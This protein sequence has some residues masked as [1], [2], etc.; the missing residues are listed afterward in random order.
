M[1]EKLVYLINEKEVSRKDFYY[2]LRNASTKLS[3]C[4]IHEIEAE[5]KEYRRKKRD[6]LYGFSVKK[7]DLLF[8]IERIK[9]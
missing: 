7:Q 8:K 9:K 1:N 5:E 6:L 2:M 4:C 3:P